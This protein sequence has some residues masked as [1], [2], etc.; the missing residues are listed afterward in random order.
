VP[1]TV[2]G[3]HA[4]HPF[5]ALR[6]H[7]PLFPELL[8]APV[9]QCVFEY[10]NRERA[11]IEL[12]SAHRADREVA[13]GVVAGKAFRVEPAEEVA[14]RARLAL[15]HIPP[16]RWWLAPDGG[17]WETPRWVA[18][19]KLRSLVEAAWLIRRELSGRS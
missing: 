10:A 18:V 6:R 1:T 19:S 2:G 14:A 7:A 8:A 12:W 5:A 17:L 13:A 16:E 3:S 11:E 9:Q 4:L 15:R